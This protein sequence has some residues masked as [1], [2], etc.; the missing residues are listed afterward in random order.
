[1]DYWDLC[2]QLIALEEA[3]AVSLVLSKLNFSRRERLLLDRIMADE[4]ASFRDL[5]LVLGISKQAVSLADQKL[6]QRLRNEF[7]AMRIAA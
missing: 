3:I 7:Q 4:P 6:K 5:G 1:M 2:E